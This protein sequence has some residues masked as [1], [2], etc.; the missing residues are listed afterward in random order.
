MD[1][2][3]FAC[4]AP[5][6]WLLIPLIAGPDGAKAGASRAALE[7][8]G[9]RMEAARPE[10]VVVIE[11]HGLLMEG[12]ISLLD[13][14][15]VHGQT[16]G[17]ADLG[18]T[19]HGYSL[20]FEVDREL[21]A[22]IVAAARPAGTPVAR[23]RNFLDFVPPH[24]DF[25]AMNPLWYLGAAFSPPPR[26]VAACVGPGVKR[27]GYIGFGR[28]VR[29]AA[30]RT[31]RRVAFI[32]SADLAHRHAPDG[33]YGFDPAAAEC[34]AAV[35]EAVRDG[36]LDRLL[37]YDAGWVARAYTEAV[38]PLLALHGLL[39]G[40]DLRPEVLCYEAPTYFGMLCAAYSPPPPDARTAP[41]P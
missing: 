5:H 11:P 38:E 3:V 39:E 1:N 41:T 33:P 32:A 9:R 12:A 31:G 40:A 22:A 27:E 29:A 8:L 18:A 17:P 25:G 24:L 15:G 6:A 30:A 10:T 34:D 13:N 28:A 37:G 26:I 19:A 4:I 16:G 35:V 14:S 20:R 23:A 7:E 36:A 21:N 2:V